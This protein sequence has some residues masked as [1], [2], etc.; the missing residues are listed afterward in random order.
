MKITV[1]GAGAWGTALARLLQSG[2]HSVTLWGHDAARLNEIKKSGANER[3]LP[4]IILPAE[5]RYEKDL[6]R[7]IDA[8][9]CVVIAVPS[10]GRLRL[11]RSN[12]TR[13][14]SRKPTKSV[15]APRAAPRHTSPGMAPESRKTRF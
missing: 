9:E 14:R 12:P 8:S 4:G 6:A 15:G 11:R 2:G 13:Q 7:A 3:Y 1:L 10:K 5:L